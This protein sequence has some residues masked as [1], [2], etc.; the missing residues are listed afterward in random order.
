MIRLIRGE[1]VTE[2]A[3][4]AILLEMAAIVT[5]DDLFDLAE[6]VWKCAVGEPPPEPDEDGVLT[7]GWEQQRDDKIQEIIDKISDYPL[8]VRVVVPPDR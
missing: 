3:L 8:P 6:L 7:P 1:P 4:A 5:D 2:A